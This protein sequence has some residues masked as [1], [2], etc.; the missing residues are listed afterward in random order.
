[1]NTLDADLTARINSGSVKDPVA[2]APGRIVLPRDPSSILVWV[3]PLG[4]APDGVIDSGIDF[5]HRPFAGTV[6][7]IF[8]PAADHGIELDD[9]IPRRGL[10]MGPQDPSELLQDGLGVLLGGSRSELPFGLANPFA[11]K[12]EALFDVRDARFFWRERKPSVLEKSLLPGASLPGST[13]PV[14]RAGDEDVI[15]PPYQVD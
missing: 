6:A 11:E 15:G 2:I 3:S 8:C 10:L 13:L 14:R 7:V 5:L 9:E 1:M 12:V 4:P